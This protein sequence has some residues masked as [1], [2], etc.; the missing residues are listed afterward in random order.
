MTPPT[1]ET[2]D[3]FGEAQGLDR[4]P[5]LREFAHVLGPIRNV[6]QVLERVGRVV[7]GILNSPEML[8]F[9]KGV[10]QFAQSMREW[11]KWIEQAP[12]QLRVALKDEGV[13]P[14]P[15]L[16]L[17]DLNSVIQEFSKD[18]GAGA[19]HRLYTLHDELFQDEAF[20]RSLQCRWQASGRWAVLEQVLRAHEL[21]LYGVSIPAALAQAEGIVVGAFR[22][23]GQLTVKK[24][25]EYLL[26]LRKSPNIDGPVL[27]QFIDD[28]LFRRFVHGDGAPLPRFSRH[29][30]LHGADIAYGTKDKSLTALVWVDYLLMLVSSSRTA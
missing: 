28:Y 12:E 20:R 1:P 4:S 9:A 5:L 16:S 17:H 14:H 27:D 30:I 8:A 15:Q 11:Q 21:G 3:T 23:S 19:V 22:H 2:Q 10:V 25:R 13:F 6:Q 7:A 26:R 24:L 18:G 29:A